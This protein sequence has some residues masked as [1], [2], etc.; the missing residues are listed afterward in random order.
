M[1]RPLIDRWTDTTA[2]RLLLF[3]SGL[4]ALPVLALGLVTTIGL[5]SVALIEQRAELDGA[6][7][8]F[9]SVGGALGMLGYLRAHRGAKE[10]S[11][12]NVTATL[13]CL[14][15]G[16]VTALAVASVVAAGA[17]ESWLSPWGS[18]TGPALA[19]PFVAAHVV[20]AVA[21]VAWMQ[22]LPRR[23]A[24]RTGRVF[25]GLPVVLLFVAVALA[26]AAALTATA[27]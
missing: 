24:E 6:T 8:V 19:A 1:N 2:F 23:Y 26:A 25:D 3:V 14:A 11:R 15:I 7:V 21:G 18:N 17:I 5:L 16:I 22:R 12:H 4:L 9:L 13:L 27:L 20:W 10:P